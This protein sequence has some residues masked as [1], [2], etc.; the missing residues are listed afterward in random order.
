M[1][2]S[3]FFMLVVVFVLASF[4]GRQALGAVK[5]YTVPGI[6]DFSGVYAEQFKQ[7]AQVQK[8]MF[9]WWN[10][11][12]GQKLGVKLNLKQYDCRFD[13]SVVASMWPGI[14][15]ESK[16]I[17][18]VG[19]GGPDMAALQQRLSHDKVPA[20]YG[21]PSYGYAWLPNQW[22]FNV[23]ATWV[24]EYLTGIIWYIKAHPEK[25]PLRFALMI[26]NLPPALDM[27]KGLE[28]YFR[29]VLE[30][31]GLGK[32]VATEYID[33]NPVDVSS[34]MKQII[35]AKADLVGGMGTTAQTA[36]YMRACRALWSQ[37]TNNGGK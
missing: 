35:D 30:P 13:A 26:P 32:I 16:P 27:K 4:M 1:K 33:M 20:T 36:A 8:A 12:V 6:G 15:A 28:K 29:E 5:E 17:I 37:Y 34:Q 21:A 19:M 2:R 25:R 22:V 23:Q 31:K 9:A 3:V 14:L 10:D 24:H 7:Q 18:L 11:T